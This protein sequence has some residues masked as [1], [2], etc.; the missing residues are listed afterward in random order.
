VSDE[1]EK[2]LDRKEKELDKSI[3]SIDAFLIG[4][5]VA[6]AMLVFGGVA[7]IILS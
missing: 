3:D 6:F 4:C 5:A 2:F 7:H 1:Y